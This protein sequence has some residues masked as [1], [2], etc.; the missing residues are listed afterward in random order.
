MGENAEVDSVRISDYLVVD[1][2]SHRHRHL[3]TVT[4]THTYSLS[5]QSTKEKEN[6]ESSNTLLT[7]YR[8]KQSLLLHVTIG[9]SVGCITFELD[10]KSECIVEQQ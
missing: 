3:S 8:Q 2:L 1:T 7:G 4:H 6:S 9:N 5:I 10:A